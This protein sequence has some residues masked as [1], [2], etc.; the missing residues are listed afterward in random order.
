VGKSSASHPTRGQPH[1][2]SSPSS[3]AHAAHDAS[4]SRNAAP[5]E[6]DQPTSQQITG[7]QNPSLDGLPSRPTGVSGRSRRVL[8]EDDDG[9]G[10]T[11]HHTKP[12]APDAPSRKGIAR[13]E[14]GRL[15]ELERQL[16]EMVV[17]K[18]ERDRHIGQLTDE[19]ALQSSLLAQAA[20]EKKHAGLE[21]RNLQEKLDEMLLSRDQAEADA[22]EAKKRAGIEQRELQ[23]IIDELILSRDELLRMLELAQSALQKATSHA[24]DADEQS[25][26]ACGHATELAEVR[27][28]LEGKKSEL[29]SVRLRLTDAEDGYAKSK[30]EADKLGAQ[31]AAGLVN[32]EVDR[33]MHRFMERMRAMETEISSLRGNE[34]STEDMECRNEG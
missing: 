1:Q 15:I 19:F 16:S 8:E 7:Q 23:A 33:V 9:E 4:P 25:Q 21:L 2:P 3:D 14:D 17:A 22:A 31:A 18:A 10:S 27:A 32:K 24:A 5:G 11:G 28:E 30:A 34:K 6:L 26:P 20:E 13:L 12:V 29:A